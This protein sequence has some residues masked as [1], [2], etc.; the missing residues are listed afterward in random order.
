MGGITQIITIQIKENIRAKLENKFLIFCSVLVRNRILHRW[1][2]IDIHHGDPESIG[3]R[4]SISI[5][6]Y[7]INIQITYIGLTW[8]TTKP[9]VYPI[10]T[11]PCWQFPSTTYLGRICQYITQINIR[12]YI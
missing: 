4:T 7:D 12:K 3:Y 5:T 8:G 2:I 6:R 9:S 10:K 1:R 11:Q